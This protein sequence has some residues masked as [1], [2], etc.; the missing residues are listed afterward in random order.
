MFIYYYR[1]LIDGRGPIANVQMSPTA[2]SVSVIPSLCGLLWNI[3][4]KFTGRNLEVALPADVYFHP[5]NTNLPP[6]FNPSNPGN[7]TICFVILSLLRSLFDYDRL[8]RL[9]LFNF[10][11]CRGWY[12]VA[13]PSGINCTYRQM[14]C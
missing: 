7:Q 13:V 8:T 9:I 10:I 6:A 12:A 14:G 4:Q 11:N 2:G 3:G 1:L 5:P